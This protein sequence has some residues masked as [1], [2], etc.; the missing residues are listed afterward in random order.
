MTTSNPWKY[1]H[2]DP[3]LVERNPFVHPSTPPPPPPPPGGSSHLDGN[4]ILM[5]KTSTYA[6]GVQ[7]L[8]D[9]YGRGECPTQPLFTESGGSKIV[10]PLTFKENIETRVNDY[11]RNNGKAERLRLFS[12]WLDSSTAIAYKKETR[13]VK[14][15]PVCPNLITIPQD[16]NEAAIS[17]GYDGLVGTELDRSEGKYN[18]LL[19]KDEVLAHPAWQ[20]ALEG[21]VALLKAYRD[22]VFTEKKGVDKLMRFWLVNNPDKDQLR[23]LCV[24]SLDNYSVAGGNDDLDDNG[25]FLRG[26]PSSSAQKK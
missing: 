4:Y 23:A 11:E 14:I 15:I 1:V 26:S 13:M 9:S 19:T 3:S 25:S 12:R 17:V 24:G 10:R 18:E 2:L 8:R 22:I 16:F 21:D 7:A 20:T 6:L 5:P